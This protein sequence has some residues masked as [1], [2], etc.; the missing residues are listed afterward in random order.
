[1]KKKIWKVI[2][3]IG[4]E[5]HPDRVKTI[6][7]KIAALSSVNDLN[8]VKFGFSGT[9]N[10]IDELSNAWL[11]S[12]MLSPH[13]LS[14]ALLGASAT[15]SLMEKREA[16]EMVWTGPSTRLVPSRHTEQVLLEVIQS[17]KQRLFIMS[18][19]AY[20]INTVEKALTEAIERKV[21]VDFLLESSKSQ[22]GKISFDSI[23]AFKLAFPMANIYSW[24]SKE[25]DGLKGAIHAKCAV[26]DGNLAFVT[27]ANLTKAAMENNMELGVLVRGGFLPNQLERHLQALITTKVVV[28]I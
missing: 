10:L 13:E 14:A 23:G 4:M 28:K 22:G 21:K 8:K 25:V 27:S 3:E 16:I 18:F 24:E 12:P 6:A 11:E 26:S 7:A 19:V 9:V 15:A 1:M 20:N 2:A 5:L 17:A